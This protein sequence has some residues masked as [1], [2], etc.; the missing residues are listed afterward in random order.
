LWIGIEI[1]VVAR[2]LLIVS[3]IIGILLG[4]FTV[5]YLLRQFTIHSD[6]LRTSTWPPAEVQLSAVMPAQKQASTAI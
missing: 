4:V 2:E 6:E 1:C 3:W 5:P